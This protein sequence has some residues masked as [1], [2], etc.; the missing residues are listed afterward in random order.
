M[1]VYNALTR[2][3]AH[4]GGHSIKTESVLGNAVAGGL[5]PTSEINWQVAVPTVI[6]DPKGASL[7]DADRSEK[8]ASDY[9]NAVE[10]A[11]RLLK[12]ETK[13]Q[14]SHAKLV[15]G[16]RQYLGETAQAHFEIA[17]ANR[18][19]A[20]KLHGLRETYAQIGFSLDRKAETVDQRVEAIASKYRGVQ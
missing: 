15:K 9:E 17:G 2:Q 4:Y 14:K 1:G 10:N 20:G 18:G 6:H 5:L 19:L 16:H 8:E 11:C 7:S 12:A 13:R 3:P